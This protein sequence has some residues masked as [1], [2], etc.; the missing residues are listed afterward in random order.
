MSI[1]AI[2]NGP[3]LGLSTMGILLPWVNANVSFI[4]KAVGEGDF[5][6]ILDSSIDYVLLSF[7]NTSKRGS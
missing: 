4:Q 7:I 1:G 6:D 5:L 3:S 2:A